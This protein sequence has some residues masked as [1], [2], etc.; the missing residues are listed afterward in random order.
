MGFRRGRGCEDA[1]MIAESVISKSIEWS[2]PVWI[3]SIDLSKAFDRIEHRALFSSLRE[4][5]VPAHYFGL[6]SRLYDHQWGT[7]GESRFSIQRGVRQG[8]VLSPMLF[9]A[10]VETVIARWKATLGE[11]DG[12][13]LAHGVQL[14]NL[15]YADDLL[16]FGRSFVEV[17]ES[18]RKLRLHLERVGLAINARKKGVDD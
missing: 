6:L 1:L 16:I 14:T 2:V 7:V 15:R 12:L 5:G 18:F 17:E 4:Q 9:N 11:E 13:T 8:D 3:I 10:A